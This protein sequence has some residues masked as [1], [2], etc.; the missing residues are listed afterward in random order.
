MA[1]WIGRGHDCEAGVAALGGRFLGATDH[2]PVSLATS[3]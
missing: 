2:D 1:V 3:G